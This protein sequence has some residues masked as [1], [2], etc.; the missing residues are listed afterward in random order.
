MVPLLG[1]RG[2]L[3]GALL[4]AVWHTACLVDN[5]GGTHRQPRAVDKYLAG[6]RRTWR[7]LWT[8]LRSSS[9]STSS[10]SSSSW[11]HLRFRFIDRL[12]P[13]PV[14]PQ[15]QVRTVQTVQK[16]SVPQ[17]SSWVVVDM[18]GVCNDRCLGLDSAEKLWRFRSCS[19]CSCWCGL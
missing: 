9:S 4:V 1:T 12:L 13:L 14:A 15:R 10:P 19:R 11:I 16:T 6:L 2:A 17:C 7:R 5:H 18:P 3:L 8:S